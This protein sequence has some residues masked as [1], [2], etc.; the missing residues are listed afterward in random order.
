MNWASDFFRSKG[1]TR[2]L[3]LAILILILFSIHSMLNLVLFTFIFSFLM[4]RL[5]NFITFHLKKI[6]PANSNL[7]II[8]LYTIVVV[9]VIIVIYRYIPVIIA[10]VT[11]LVRQI[12]YFYEHPPDNQTIVYA[13][14]LAKN[15]VSPEDVEKHFNTI[16]TYVTTLGKAS[17]QVILAII[18]SLFFLL[19]KK[20]IMK[21]SQNFKFGK[22]GWFFL[23]LEYFG[24]KF[25]NTFG[26]VIEVQFTIAFVNAVLSTLALWILGFPQLIG[27]AIMIFFLGLIPVAGVFVSLIPLVT[28]AYSIG[29]G[30]KVIYVLA[31]ITILHALEAYVLNPKFMSAKTN[32]PAFYTF[33]VLIFS[34]HFLGIWGL[35][36]GIPI[37]IF[38]LDIMDIKDY[39]QK[40]K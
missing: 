3:T 16:Y 31:M 17:M 35:I 34:E 10:Q 26:K 19:E 15:F 9:T 13:L 7:V 38:L 23:E 28:I 33:L 25:V 40:L 11:T 14:N 39:E 20:R 8:V 1:F 36:I 37:F 22:F 6:V 27:L 4:G 18:L 21:F 29:G 32:L 12:I 2:F 30:M 24:R 5:Q